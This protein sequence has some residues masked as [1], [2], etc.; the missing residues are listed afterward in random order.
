MTAIKFIAL[1]TPAI[2]GLMVGGFAYWIA[3]RPE[4]RHP[5]E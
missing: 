3:T 4:K 5:A 2:G 1:L